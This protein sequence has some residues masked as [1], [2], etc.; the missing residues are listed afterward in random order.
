LTGAATGRDDRL[1]RP[2]RSGFSEAEE[3]GW[4][5]DLAPVERC[6]LEP[7]QPL[8]R[9]LLEPLVALSLRDQPQE[10][11]DLD[12]AGVRR[13]ADRIEVR[14][15]PLTQLLVLLERDVRLAEVE[16]AD[17]ADRHQ[18]VRAVP[19]V[20]KMRAFRWR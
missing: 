2:S 9:G 6:N 12:A 13:N 7:L 20:R 18:R 15:D 5:E 16:R 8:V 3:L 17:V 19:A 1:E 14:V 11:L 4:T 10:V